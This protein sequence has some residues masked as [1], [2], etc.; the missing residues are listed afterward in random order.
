MEYVYIVHEGDRWLSKETLRVKAVCE[1]LDDAIAIIMKNN[2][3][4]EPNAE[5][6]RELRDYYQSFG[7]DV[8]YMIEVVDMNTWN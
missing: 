3:S 6:E 4:D 1:T 5:M 7:D 8:R 2:V